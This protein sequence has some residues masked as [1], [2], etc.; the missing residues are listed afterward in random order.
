MPSSSFADLISFVWQF[1]HQSVE[2]GNLVKVA[3]VHVEQNVFKQ[4]DSRSDVRRRYFNLN[5]K[6]QSK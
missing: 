5:L 3:E 4:P 1:E 6:C 2:T